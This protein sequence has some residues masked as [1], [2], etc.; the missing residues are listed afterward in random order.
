VLDARLARW[1]QIS[2]LDCC[3]ALQGG[4]TVTADSQYLSFEGDATGDWVILGRVVVV[5]RRFH[6]QL[7]NR[8]SGQS[9]W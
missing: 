8:P 3:R 2:W 5:N 1:G 6:E 7:G 4:S 9:S